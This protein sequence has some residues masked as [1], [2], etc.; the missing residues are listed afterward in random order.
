MAHPV[1]WE[2]ARLRPAF[3]A[4]LLDL[5]MIVLTIAFFGIALLYMQACERLR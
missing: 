4:P 1:N 3:E 2:G 5:L